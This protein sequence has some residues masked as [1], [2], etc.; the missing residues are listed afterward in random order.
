MHPE[1]ASNCMLIASYVVNLVHIGEG[2]RKVWDRG[3]EERRKQ[4]G[5]D[6][7]RIKK[8]NGREGGREGGGLEGGRE[9]RKG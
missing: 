9:G 5:K 1:S 6:R 2:R 3:R 7:R 4:R 8:V